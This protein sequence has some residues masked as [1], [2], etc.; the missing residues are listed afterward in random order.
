MTGDDAGK[1]EL[2]NISSVAENQLILETSVT[3]SYPLAD[4]ITQVIVIPRIEQITI[5]SGG[6]LTTNSWD[7]TTGGVLYLDVN[8][9]NVEKRRCGSC[10]CYRVWSGRRSRRWNRTHRWWMMVVR[11]L[12]IV[13]L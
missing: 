12:Q 13:N 9:I 10:R 2:L 11:G 1:Y 5:Q 6:E 8:E 4:G 3:L 7:G